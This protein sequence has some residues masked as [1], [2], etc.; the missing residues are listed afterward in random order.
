MT[1]TARLFMAALIILNESTKLLRSG[2]ARDLTPN[3][4]VRLLVQYKQ[5]WKFADG[6]REPKFELPS[7][8]LSP[9]SSFC[10]R[11]ELWFPSILGNI[12]T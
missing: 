11:E 6:C 5:A 12:A 7:S 2:A 4:H 10:K 8:V 3:S 9:R 1:E